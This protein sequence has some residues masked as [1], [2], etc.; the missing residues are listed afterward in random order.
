MILG[1][2]GT[3]EPISDAQRKWLW[4]LFYPDEGRCEIDILHHG[5]CE[6][7]DTFAH[8]Y[9]LGQVKEI[10]I[11]PPEDPKHVDL[12]CFVTTSTRT[13]IVVLPPRPYL[14]R[15]EDIVDAS[16]KLVALPKT[17]FEELRSG[18][19]STVR[20]ARAHDKPGMIVWPDGRVEEWPIM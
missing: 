13:R 17:H 12:S 2:T 18:T 20:Y 8:H 5:A 3:R 11:H 4:R 14:K 1:F 16:S 6:N 7:A 19:W 9:A 15:N 10:V